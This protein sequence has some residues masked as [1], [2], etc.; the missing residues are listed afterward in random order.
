[1]GEKE[2]MRSQRRWYRCGGFD[3]EGEGEAQKAR[4]E[5][6]LRLRSQVLRR[7]LPRPFQVNGGFAKH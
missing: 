1:M 3:E 4:E 5:T 6:E 2:G 7:E